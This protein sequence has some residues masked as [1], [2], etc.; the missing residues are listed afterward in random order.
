MLREH[1]LR[2]TFSLAQKPT[3]AAAPASFWDSQQGN[4]LL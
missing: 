4:I 2:E 1:R 3:L